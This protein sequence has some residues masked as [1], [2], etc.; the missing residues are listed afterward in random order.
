M[1]LTWKEIAAKKRDALLNSFPSKW[2]I[3]DSM[4]PPEHELDVTEFPH[5]SGWFDDHELDITSRDAVDILARLRNGEW[6]SEEVTNA[7]CKRAAAA[8]QLVCF[9]VERPYR[10]QHIWFDLYPQIITS[11]RRIDQLPLRDTI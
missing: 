1:S 10:Y 6:T 9:V 8:H 3:P 7:F 11:D 5:K 2:I 4:R